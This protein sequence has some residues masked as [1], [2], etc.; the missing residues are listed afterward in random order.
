MDLAIHREQASP[1]HVC[2]TV[3]RY[4]LVQ[5]IVQQYG[6]KVTPDLQSWGFEVVVRIAKPAKQEAAPE[7]SGTP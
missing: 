5:I 3:L 7:S 4:T 2:P 1:S 6:R